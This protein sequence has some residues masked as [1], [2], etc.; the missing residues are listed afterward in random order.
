ME[1]ISLQRKYPASAEDLWA[2][3]TT[4]EGIEQW[5]A[6]D[7][8]ETNVSAIDVRPGGELVYTMTARGEEQ[9]AFMESAG[10]P[11][12]T[13]S[14]KTFGEVE[15]PRK[16]SYRSLID[17]VP[18]QESYEH[19]TVVELAPAPDGSEV[20]MTIEPLHNEE[21]TERIVAGRENELD[22]LARVL[23]ASGA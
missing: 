21:W 12:A 6:P 5:W 9:I 8:F 22:N 10:M 16:L 18:G 20:V 3:W 11:L 4:A 15:A 23:G 17:F 13:E 19:L 14:R 7:G 2:L 1:N